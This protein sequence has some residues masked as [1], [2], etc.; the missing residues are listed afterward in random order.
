MTVYSSRSARRE[1]RREWWDNNMLMIAMYV[2]LVAWAVIIALPI[3][4]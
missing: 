3:F 2:M 1:Q 4:V